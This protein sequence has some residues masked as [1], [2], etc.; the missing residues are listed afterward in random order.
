MAAKANLFSFLG[1]L[2]HLDPFPVKN[3][4]VALIIFSSTLG[5]CSG[6]CRSLHIEHFLGSHCRYIWKT[7][8]ESQSFRNP[9]LEIKSD[10]VCVRSR[11]E[12]KQKAANNQATP[13]SCGTARTLWKGCWRIALGFVSDCRCFLLWSVIFKLNVF[14]C[15]FCFHASFWYLFR[16]IHYKIWYIKEYLTVLFDSMINTTST[17][18]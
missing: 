16:Q 15:F 8:L 6:Q 3:S 5:S 4:S 13:F 7:Q 10:Q 1:L 17:C 2:K 11:N 12:S 18:M 14:V 9:G